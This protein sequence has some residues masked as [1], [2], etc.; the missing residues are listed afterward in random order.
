MIVAHHTHASPHTYDRTHATAHDGR[1]KRWLCV[2]PFVVALVATNGLLKAVTF[3]LGTTHP[4][5]HTTHSR[6]LTT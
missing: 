6:R 1:I 5:P 2:S 4:H 3:I